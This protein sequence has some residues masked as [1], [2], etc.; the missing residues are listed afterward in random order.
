MIKKRLSIALLLILTISFFVTPAQATTNID[1]QT[2]KWV[3][4]AAQYGLFLKFMESD[5][6]RS[7]YTKPR[8]ALL[9]FS[10]LKFTF[11]LQFQGSPRTCL[12]AVASR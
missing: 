10:I 6:I 5:D 4:S 2:G 9:V 7:P 12:S 11:P 1:N 8:G 3:K